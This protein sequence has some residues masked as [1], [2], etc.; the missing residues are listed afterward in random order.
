MAEQHFFARVL[1]EH[2]S[3]HVT[4]LEEG[5]AAVDGG[6]GSLIPDLPPLLLPVRGQDWGLSSVEESLRTRCK[7][8]TNMNENSPA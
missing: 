2:V 3:D 8:L 7:T 5:I 6:G 1:Y 4:H